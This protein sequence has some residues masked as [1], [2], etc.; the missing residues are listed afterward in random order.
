MIDGN[1][2]NQATNS[3]SN[4]NSINNNNHHQQQQQQ[5]QQQSLSLQLPPSSSFTAMQNRGLNLLN[6]FQLPSYNGTGGV[7]RPIHHHSQH[8]HNHQGRQEVLQGQNSRN[9]STMN[10]T[11]ENIHDV[12]DY[13]GYQ[14]NNHRHN[15]GRQIFHSL[16]LPIP[17]AAAAVEAPPYLHQKSPIALLQEEHERRKNQEL[18]DERTRTFH[19]FL[20]SDQK[21]LGGGGG[22]GGAKN[23][24]DISRKRSRSSSSCSS[25]CVEES[26]KEEDT[27]KNYSMTSFSNTRMEQKSLKVQE[28][29]EVGEE[30]GCSTSNFNSSHEMKNRNETHTIATTGDNH[31][32]LPTLSSSGKS[33]SPTTDTHTGTTTTQERFHDEGTVGNGDC[34]G[35]GLLT[36]LIKVA[37]NGSNNIRAEKPADTD[38][39]SLLAMA[40]EME[41]QQGYLDTSIV[42]NDAKSTPQSRKLET[43]KTNKNTRLNPTT[44]DILSSLPTL[45]CEPEY[46]IVMGN[47]HDQEWHSRI[48]LNTKSSGLLRPYSPDMEEDMESSD[49]VDHWFPSC[50]I[51]DDEQH[52]GFTKEKK[53]DS[54]HTSSNDRLRYTVEPG[55]IE[56]LP[57]CKIHEKT[58]K[59]QNRKPTDEHLFCFQVTE[60]YCNNMILCCSQCSTW[61]H[62]ECGGHY[63]YCSPRK[64]EEN[65]KPVCDR[66]HEEKDVGKQYSHVEKFLARQRDIHL[67]KTLMS[68]DIIRYASYSKHG[69]GC[70]WPLGSVIPSHIGGHYR[71][72]QIRNERTEKQW[73]EMLQRLNSD[74]G[75][76]AKQKSK[77]L[78]FLLNRLEEAE[79]KTDLHNMI[80]FLERDEK[81]QCPIGFERPLF[82]FFDPEED[83]CR[84]AFQNKNYSDDSSTSSD[85]NSESESPSDHEDIPE[86]K[87][88]HDTNKSTNNQSDVVLGRYKPS[89]ITKKRT[90]VK[91]H[92]IREG[93]NRKPRFDSAFCSDACGVHVM[94]QDLLR[95]LSFVNGMHPSRLHN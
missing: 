81:R 67:R 45:P 73:A 52:D 4:S 33:P 27:T 43:T 10:F 16:P 14:R 76:N 85:E 44:D 40:T 51:E 13:F 57:Y 49:V 19:E 5:Q 48:L 64:C 1:N 39:M 3:A 80:L 66:C 84:L 62:A 87:Q 24:H 9:D 7:G 75:T 23:H 31:D 15:F 56:K 91:R 83:H 55:V 2:R 11:S 59:E 74:S 60:M 90:K 53:V 36:D 77:D 50:P 70:K 28:R 29:Q 41:M 82:N 21:D 68:S 8:Q 65:F 88:D 92:C 32:A 46:D 78:Q 58:L 22:G 30:S 47:Y 20:F 18:H 35:N 79:G 72:V 61:R 42:E 37:L 69:L 34:E 26:N 38:G 54:S 94:Q 12:D 93:C 25:S 17:A 89:T 95:S 6:L 86:S 63:T 71:S